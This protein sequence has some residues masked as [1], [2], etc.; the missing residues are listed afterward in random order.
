MVIRIVSTQHNTKKIEQ[1]LFSAK[2]VKAK[3]FHKPR[4]YAKAFLAYSIF[5]RELINDS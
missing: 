5:K 3:E 1:F 4:P 2:K